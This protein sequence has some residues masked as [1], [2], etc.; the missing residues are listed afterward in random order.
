MASSGQWL[1]GALQPG[2]VILMQAR[3]R[4]TN[5]AGVYLGATTLR[6]APHLPPVPDAM[7]HHLYGRLSER[8]VYG[9][10][11]RQITR[12]IIRYQG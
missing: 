2:D 4:R 8:T 11:W 7:L 5:H 1:G 9:G 3:S 12:L 6:E 10:H